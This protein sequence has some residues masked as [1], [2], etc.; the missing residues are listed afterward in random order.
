MLE[1]LKHL[2]KDTLLFINGNNSPFWDSFMITCTDK[3]FWFPFYAVL[4]GYLIWKF[5][6]KS[7][8]IFIFI[9]LLIT[10]ADQ[11]ASTLMKPLFERLRPCHDPEISY[12]LHLAK[13]CGGKFG[14]ISS[15]SANT[16]AIAAFITLLL[17][18][19]MI[20]VV[21]YLWAFVVSYSRIYLGVHFPGDILA[22]ALAGI[23]FGILYF[24]LYR[25]FAL[26]LI[27]HKL[28][29]QHT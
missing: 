2:D 11:F 9:A 7:I 6:M 14:F 20:G 15:H 5:R 10:S 18:N 29:K 28:G 17:N 27:E 13:G 19:T 1:Y 26:K 22:G 12:M 25:L 24:Y 16:F 3:F 4:L 23:F 8:L 21:I